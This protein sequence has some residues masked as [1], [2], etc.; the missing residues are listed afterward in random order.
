MIVDCFLIRAD[1]SSVNVTVELHSELGRYESV[2]FRRTLLHHSKPS[3]ASSQRASCL[4]KVKLHSLDLLYSF[5]TCCGLLSTA[6]QKCIPQFNM[7]RDVVDLLW[8]C[9]KVVDLL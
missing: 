8:T 3:N 9:R 1:L 6:M 5:S 7:H 2:E 4:Y